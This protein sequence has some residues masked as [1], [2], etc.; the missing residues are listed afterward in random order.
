MASVTMEDSSQSPG[1]MVRKDPGL[2]A[3]VT[4]TSKQFFIKISSQTERGK[5]ICIMHG[6]I[7][8]LLTLKHFS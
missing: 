8:E 2:S 7:S 1:G 4:V 6:K 5:G 3:G